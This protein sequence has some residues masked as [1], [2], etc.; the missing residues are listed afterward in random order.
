MKEWRLYH[1]QVISVAPKK[2]S[3]DRFTIHILDASK[4]PWVSSTTAYNVYDFML[5]AKIWINDLKDKK[6][7]VRENTNSQL[8]RLF[9]D[10]TMPENSEKSRELY[11]FDRFMLYD[12][13]RVDMKSVN[14]L[15]YDS[16]L[17]YI[18]EK[19][20]QILVRDTLY[21][22]PNYV[23]D[24]F[25]L[26]DFFRIHEFYPEEAEA[27][28]LAHN[29]YELAKLQN[30][31]K[32]ISPALQRSYHDEYLK[33]VLNKKSAMSYELFLSYVD[34]ISYELQN[35]PW[36]QESVFNTMVK[37]RYEK[38]SPRIK[39]YMLPE[40]PLYPYDKETVNYVTCLYFIQDV[41]EKYYNDPAFS[42]NLWILVDVA[43]HCYRWIAPNIH[44]DEEEKAHIPRQ[45]LHIHDVFHFNKWIHLVLESC[46]RSVCKRIEAEYERW[47]HWQQRYIDVM[48]DVLHKKIWGSFDKLQWFFYCVYLMDCIHQKVIA[49]NK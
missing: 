41:W 39:Y 5:D 35:N 48:A 10:D 44:P 8:A 27:I 9:L 6:V 47:E 15:L 37:D 16:Q 13:T 36:N 3:D 24:Y 1:W 49:N 28:F 32:N 23:L 29:V 2:W 18:L 4:A 42:K 33:F 12:Y 19:D 7:V 45:N 34:R 22:L 11:K 21:N 38:L 40:A 30:S 31:L 43:E 25:Y 46:F 17:K 14:Q 26:H 20:N